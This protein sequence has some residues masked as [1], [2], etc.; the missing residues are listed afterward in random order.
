MPNMDK[1]MLK[2]ASYYYI[3]SV[4]TLFYSMYHN[5]PYNTHDCDPNMAPQT[6]DSWIWIEIIIII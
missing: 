2:R 6:Y 1:Y 4:E 5:I 3:D